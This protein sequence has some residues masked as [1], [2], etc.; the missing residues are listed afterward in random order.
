MLVV[1]RDGMLLLYCTVIG[2]VAAGIGASFFKM[3][4]SQP[5][6]FGLLGP[7]WFGVATTFVFCALAG[8]AII[9]DHA[10]E[11]GV[12]TDGLRWLALGVLIAAMWSACSGVLVLQLIVTLTGLPA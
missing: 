3:V 9:M 8:P 1:L 10:I 11:R 4:T 5:A 12:R 7:S 2:F 6:R